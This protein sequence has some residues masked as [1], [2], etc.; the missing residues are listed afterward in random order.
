MRAPQYGHGKKP[1]KQPRENAL[2]GRVVSRLPREKRKSR[3]DRRWYNWN[4]GRDYG[5]PLNRQ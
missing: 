1:P 5:Q 2:L 3:N 4:F